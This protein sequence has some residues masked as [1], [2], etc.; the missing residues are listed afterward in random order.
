MPQWTWE[1]RYLVKI[2]ILFPSDRYPEVEL[3]DHMIV[4]FLNFR[5]SF[6]LFHSGCAILYSQYW[7]PRIPFRNGPAGQ[8]SEGR[9]GQDGGRGALVLFSA[10]PLNTSW[11]HLILSFYFLF[12]S[13][14]NICYWHF[15]G[16]GGRSI[17]WD[18]PK[19]NNLKTIQ[20]YEYRRS[21]SDEHSPDSQGCVEGEP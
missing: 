18:T 6:I 7:S 12:Y 1:C 10:L 4:L 19:E 14:E 15:S 3:L 2:A 11:S 9:W 16:I 20:G 5:V 21:Y 8:L 17:K 13:N